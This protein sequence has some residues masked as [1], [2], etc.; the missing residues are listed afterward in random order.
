M[1]EDNRLQPVSPYGVSKLAGENLAY[2]YFKNFKVPTVSLR[3]FTVYGEGQ[4]P[5]MAFHIFIK[6]FLKG[7]EINIFGDGKQSRNFTYVEDIA[8]ANIL[9]A[10]K[11]PAGEIINIGGSG[12]GIILNDTISMIKELTG[13]ETEINYLKKVKGDVKHTSADTSKAEKLL[14]YQPTV[15][16]KE[17]LQREVEWLK[18]IY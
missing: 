4:R 7:E 14:G 16:F 18:E 6:A 3:Y 2:L 9:A 12:K 17:G 15:S 13:R 10:R 1:H 5:D 11:S 8:R